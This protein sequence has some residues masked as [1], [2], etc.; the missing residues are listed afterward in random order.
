[1]VFQEDSK[2]IFILVT[3]NA[4]LLALMAFLDNLQAEIMSV[5][6]VMA[7]VMDVL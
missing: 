7:V 5:V 2:H 4:M 3:I 1:M 6:P